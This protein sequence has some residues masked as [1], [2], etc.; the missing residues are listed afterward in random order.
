MFGLSLTT[1]GMLCIHNTPKWVNDMNLLIDGILQESILTRQN[2]LI[3]RGRLASVMLLF[4]TTWQV[5]LQEI[6]RHAYVKPFLRNERKTHRSL[7]STA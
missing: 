5:A 7:G 2:A 3:L 1:D 4:W 6:I